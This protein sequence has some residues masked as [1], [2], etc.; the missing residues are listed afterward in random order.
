MTVS[1]P[2]LEIQHTAQQ[3]LR[4]QHLS[5][6]DA[7]PLCGTTTCTGAASGAAAG[8]ATGNLAARVTNSGRKGGRPDGR[9][10]A[11]RGVGERNR[12]PGVERRVRDSGRVRRWARSRG[13]Q[14]PGAGNWKNIYRNRTTGE[15][16]TKHGGNV[17][18]FEPPAGCMSVLSFRGTSP[19]S[20]A[21]LAPQP[22]PSPTRRQCYSP[23]SS[24]R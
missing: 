3:T 1:L 19:R 23:T 22:T 10:H 16:R 11:E 20:W 9:G 24:R 6:A 18:V 17:A 13:Q 21:S 15:E 14:G 12:L 7:R 8:V 2:F 5:C 4:C